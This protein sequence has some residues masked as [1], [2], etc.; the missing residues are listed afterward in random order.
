MQNSLADHLKNIKNDQN[1][2]RNLPVKW[3][4]NEVTD[5][6]SYR[7]PIDVFQLEF[8][9]LIFDISPVSAKL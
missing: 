4:G 5:I 8:Q 1:S 3:V 7:T 2:I 9:D 6:H